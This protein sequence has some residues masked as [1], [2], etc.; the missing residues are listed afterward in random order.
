MMVFI[1]GVANCLPAVKIDMDINFWN[2][3]NVPKSVKTITGLLCTIF[4]PSGWLAF[5]VHFVGII[6]FTLCRYKKRK[7]RRYW[8]TLP[9]ASL[10]YALF[11]SVAIMLR[12]SRNELLMGHY[13]WVVSL[14]IA[15]VFYWKLTGKREVEAER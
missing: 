2:N 7:F 1:Y 5:S 8:M 12:D 15:I 6:L 9:V 13:L 11:D 4:A 10:T 3:A 14:L